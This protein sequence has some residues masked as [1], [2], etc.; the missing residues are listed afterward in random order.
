VE[1]TTSQWSRFIEAAFEQ[2]FAPEIAGVPG[3]NLKGR[4]DSSGTQDE[5]DV[6]Y[7]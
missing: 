7:E 6:F 5:S 1:S 4:P 2:A 3:I